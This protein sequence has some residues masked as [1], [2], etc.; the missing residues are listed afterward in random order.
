MSLNTNQKRALE[1]QMRFLEQALLE[2]RERLCNAPKDGCLV[3]YR[4]MADPAR[5]RILAMIEPMLSEIAFIARE[6]DLQASTEDDGSYIRAQMAVAWSDLVDMLSPKLRRYG[7]VDEALS[8]TL[9]PHI[10]L[11][12]E[13]AQE[14]ARATDVEPPE[15]PATEAGWE[16][17][18]EEIA[19]RKP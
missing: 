8:E 13:L 1:V 2:I 4:P 9:D 10:Q 3:S 19:W 7:P 12:I 15:L 6:F 11:L 14:T 5:A 17:W 18:D 16:S